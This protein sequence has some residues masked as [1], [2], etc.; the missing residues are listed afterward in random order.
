MVIEGKIMSDNLV[1][2]TDDNFETEVIKSSAPVLV[3]F[4]A[5]W[6]GP[7]KMIAPE[8]EKIADEKSSD[9]LKIG[10]VNVDECRD[11]AIK[12]G[13]SSIPTLLLFKDGEVA[14][15][16]VGAMGKDKIL[17]EIGEFI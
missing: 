3:D 6:C 7:C 15:K 9:V 5:V 12:Y 11:T 4:W 1:Q 2:L 8:L 10:K 16:L 13:I 14:K 17:D